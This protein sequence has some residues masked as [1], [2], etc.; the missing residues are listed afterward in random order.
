MF[1]IGKNEHHMDGTTGTT[2]VRI[3]RPFATDGPLH[4]WHRYLLVDGIGAHL[5]IAFVVCTVI[6]DGPEHVRTVPVIE[7]YPHTEHWYAGDHGTVTDIHEQF[8]AR[9]RPCA[10]HGAT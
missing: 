3:V 2:H 4:T 9:T 5:Q 7:L 8:I 6:T 10:H 1:G